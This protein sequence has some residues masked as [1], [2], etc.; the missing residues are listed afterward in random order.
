MKLSELS[1]GILLLFSFS[2]CVSQQPDAETECYATEY[3][4]PFI[5][6]DFT[7]NTY[8]GA[9]APFGMVQLSPDNGLPGWDRISGYFYPDSTIAGF[10]HTH[11]SGTG[12][13]DLYDISFMPVTLP[14]KEADAPLGIHSLFSHD[15]ETASAGYYQVRLKDY[16]INVEL[17]ATERCGI[18]R[19]T[20]PEAD[21][22][23]FLNLRKAMNWDFTNDTRIEV[24]DSVTIQ[25][26]R[27]SDGWAR[28]QHIYFRTRFSKPFASVQLDTATVI[29][30]GKRIGSSAIA[31][32]DFHTSA[33]EQILVTT[34]ISGVSMEGAARNLAAE[35]P[36]DDF[37]KYLAVTRKNWNEQLSKVE[38]K[39]NDIDE[40]VKFYTA[41]YHS[42]LAPTIY[43]DMDG[44]YYGPDKQV[45]QADGWTNYSTF[46]LWDTY[47][48]AHPL[49][50]YI[51]PQRVNDMVKSFLAFSEQNGR[52]PVWNFYG[53]ET[54]MMIGYHAVPVIVD[55]YL[56]GIGDFDPKKALAACVATANIDE[57][58]GIGLYKKYG[59]VPYDVTDH[60]NSENWSL[61]KT[62][63]Y[64]YDD[65]C[66]ARMAE[67]LGERQI[68]DEF[69]K[70]SRN[71]KNVYNSQ[72]TFMQPRNNKG[73]FIEDFSPDDYTPH[74]CE[75]NG[76][77]Y[78]WS[79]QQDVDGLI[80][81]VGGKERFAQ[82]LDSMF[83]YNPSADEDLP[84]FSTGMIGQYAHGNEPS[85]HVIYLFNA[86][87]QPWKTQKYA[88]E[89]MHELYKNTPAG[90]C[91][92]EDCG[93]M[94]A[95]YVFSAMGFYPVDPI[96]GKYE[97]GTPMYPEM[98]MHLANG[99]TFTI[100]APAVSK[101]NIYIQSVKLDGN[102]YDK[103]YITHEQIMNGSIFEF[104][105][106]NKPG[107]VWYE[108]E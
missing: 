54:D 41:L 96:S 93:Q 88:A 64:A 58:R 59:Y 8:P 63:E 52:L 72:T 1:F 60:Y 5:G 78:F 77:Q 29:K 20:F 25:G 67:K 90:L 2:A 55:A 16:D 46:S 22:A 4:N 17:T 3:V 12:A 80:S 40:K 36:A 38:I 95:W 7:G 50:T 53:S 98:K 32:F 68:A 79:V 75:S 47:R 69:D 86:I 42:M 87:G 9:Q 24:V 37:D 33:G 14:Y 104:E 82:K 91:G 66:I 21:A 89:V 62:L 35:A 108:I 15:E 61:S 31:R 57:Y 34:A 39:S 94:S 49:Y 56:K 76:W 101:E 10:S 11:L 28:D 45:H 70:R 105:M 65:Y 84:I 23:I 30:D 100:L 71:Y 51:E 107:K 43:S 6:T 48:A 103:S 81:L 27:F 97:I 106:G 83:T 44:A 19:Y 85:H 99:K 74:I 13:G 18:Q 92:N 26:Y 73:S 102:P